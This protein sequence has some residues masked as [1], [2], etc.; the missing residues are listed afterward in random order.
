MGAFA[1]HIRQRTKEI[2]GQRLLN[3]KAPLDCIRIF[4]ISLFGVRRICAVRADRI[5]VPRLELR[6][7]LRPGQFFGVSA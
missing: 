2:G 7:K 5:A 3:G 1:S 6:G 4:A